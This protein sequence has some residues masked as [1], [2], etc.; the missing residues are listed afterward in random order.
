MG[1]VIRL[2]GP[3]GVEL[4]GRSV[5]SLLPGRQGRLLFA[6]L[7][8]NRD[9]DCG[10][11][12]LID[13]LWPEQPPAAADTALSALLSKLRKALGEGALAGRS[14]LRF[15][16]GADI[17][18][19]LELAARA[20][21]RAESAV[22]AH[23]W[24]EA[25]ASARDALGVDLQTFLPDCDGPWLNELRRELENIRLRALEAL[26]EA[27]LRQG[28]RELGAAEQAARAVIAAAPFRESAHRL[29]MEVYEAAGNPAEALRAFEELRSLLRE[30]LGTTPG[31]AA[32]TVFERVL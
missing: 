19:D 11:P 13:L 20:A 15:V 23:D 3:M 10:R 24:A 7:I 12:E 8:L 1:W 21:A 16:P 25:A 17:E 27:C 14:E 29:L 28:G 31:P 22:D 6:Y 26:G 18:V 9:R 2:C 32:M 4:G 5:G 30:E